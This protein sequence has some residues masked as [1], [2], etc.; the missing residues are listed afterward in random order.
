[1][2]IACEDL[3]LLDVEF[4]RNLEYKEEEKEFPAKLEPIFGRNMDSEAKDSRLILRLEIGERGNKEHP[5]YCRLAVAA[6]FNWN[7]LSEEAAEK[8]IMSV[9]VEIVSSFIRTYLY[10]LMQKAGMEPMV[11]PP[12]LFGEINT[13]TE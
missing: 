1:M 10:D 3:I 7:E 4:I 2:K 11:L 6:I 8:E 13:Y 12:I 5:F 9:G